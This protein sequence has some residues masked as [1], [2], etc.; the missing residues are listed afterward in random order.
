MICEL[1]EEYKDC[2][3]NLECNKI[4]EE[5]VYETDNTGRN[6]RKRQNNNHTET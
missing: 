3:G 6:R 2:K 1:C 5:I 4:I